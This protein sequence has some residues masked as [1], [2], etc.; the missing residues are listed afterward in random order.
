LA[1]RA[2][3]ATLDIFEQD[4]VLESNRTKANYLNAAADELSS[5]SKVYN[6]RNCGM[7]WAFEVDI[8]D[9]QFSEKFFQAGLKQR[10]LLRPLDNTV[11]FMPP[12]IITEE[13]IDLLVNGTLHILNTL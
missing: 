13:E 7:I 6:F 12:Y 1:C 9:P 2:A 4:N 11:Y 8:D 10:L 5:H 3:L